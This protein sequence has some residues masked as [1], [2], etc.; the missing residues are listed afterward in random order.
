MIYS[1]VFRFEMVNGIISITYTAG[2]I[3]IVQNNNCKNYSGTLNSSPVSSGN[4]N[5]DGQIQEQKNREVNRKFK[6]EMV[7]ALTAWIRK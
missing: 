1:E 7:F 5:A 2:K 3:N 6:L 4:I